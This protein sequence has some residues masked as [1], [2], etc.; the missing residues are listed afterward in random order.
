M[1][2]K[3]QTLP[4]QTPRYTVVSYYLLAELFMYTMNFIIN[5]KAYRHILYLIIWQCIKP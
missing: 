4:R 2:K 5:V 3:S 1:L